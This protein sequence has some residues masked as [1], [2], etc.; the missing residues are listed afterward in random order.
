MFLWLSMILV[1]ILAGDV[2]QNGRRYL[3][4]LDALTA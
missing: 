3:T 2:I 4:K 1:N